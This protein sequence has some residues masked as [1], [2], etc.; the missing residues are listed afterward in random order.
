MTDAR[1]DH[2][3]SIVGNKLVVVGGFANQ[4]FLKSIEVYDFERNSW[5]K[6]TDP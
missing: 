3:S 4:T 2:S 5:D 1:Y 6:F